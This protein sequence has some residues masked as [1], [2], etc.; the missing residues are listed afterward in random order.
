MTSKIPE[1]DAIEFTS[2]RAIADYARAL[3][4]LGRTLA[5]ELD[6]S[7]EELSAVLGRQKGHPLLAGVDVRLRSRRV[8]KRLFRA[9]ELAQGVATEAVRFNTEFRMQFA[10]ILNPRPSSRPA[11]DFNDDDGGHVH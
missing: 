2:P 8:A 5:S 11:F 9:A 7:A 3:R 10:E 1:L 6:A 4:T